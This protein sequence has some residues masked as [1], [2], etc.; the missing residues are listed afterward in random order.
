[1]A[2]PPPDDDPLELDAYLA[3][4]GYAGPRDATP[5]TLAAVHA[6]HA[7]RIPFEN[8][9]ILLGRPIRI[10]VASV[11]AKLV[12]A[13]RGGYCYEHN[14]LLAAALRALGF[15][16]EFLGARVRMGPPRPTAR[17][18]CVLRV[19]AG[20]T[21]WLADVGFGLDGLI[22]PVPWRTGEDLA[23]GG[24][25]YRLEPEGDEGRVVVLVAL[26]PAGPLPLYA[27]RADDPLLPIDL[28]LGNWFT[29]THPRSPFT[30]GLVAQR[31]TRASR[32]LLRNRELT[33]RRGGETT[34]T[35]VAD[36]DHLLAVLREH[37]ELDFPAGTRFRAPVF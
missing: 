18:H 24:Q 33:V 35:E 32:A 31:T 27:I 1:M 12:G 6:A 4:I 2:P 26:Q 15:E 25:R 21:A 7:Q 30:G 13:R 36:P 22:D 28:E 37:F 23:S 19:A 10:D 14:T 3:R 8:L 34:T 17:T 16:V 11:A 20:G 5:E 29:S 9:D